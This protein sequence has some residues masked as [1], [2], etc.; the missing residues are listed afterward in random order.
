MIG[1]YGFDVRGPSSI[2]ILQQHY[3]SNVLNILRDKL[4]AEVLVTGVPRCVSSEFSEGEFTEPGAV[5]VLS[6]LVRKT[7]TSCSRRRHR[8]EASTS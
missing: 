5:P 8:N 6:R 7:W 4:G 1:L 3:W 2:P